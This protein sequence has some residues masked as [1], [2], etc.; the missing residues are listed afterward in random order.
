MISI[1]FMIVLSLDV[2]E[3]SLILGKDTFYHVAMHI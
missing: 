1:C 3:I 2:T